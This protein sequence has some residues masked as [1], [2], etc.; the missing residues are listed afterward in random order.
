MA[1][2]EHHTVGEEGVLAHARCLGDGVVGVESHDQGAQSRGKAG[3][4]EYRT[5]VHAGIREDRRVDHGDVSHGQKRGD[6]RDYF[7][8]DAA[9]MGSKAEIPID[10]VL[11]GQRTCARRSK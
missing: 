10:V 1:H 9:A 11:H 2:A 8:A 5:E 6:A 4:D 7:L 3:G